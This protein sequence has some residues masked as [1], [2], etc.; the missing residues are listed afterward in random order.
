MCSKD[1]GFNIRGFC[2][3]LALCVPLSVLRRHDFRSV[4]QYCC[5]EFENLAVCLGVSASL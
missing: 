2:G 1:E 3:L 4:C 5:L